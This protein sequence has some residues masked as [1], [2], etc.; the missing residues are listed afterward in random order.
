MVG[1][2]VLS[3]S[4]YVDSHGGHRT[5]ER[6]AVQL[7]CSFASSMKMNEFKEVQDM[8]LCFFKG[9]SCSRQSAGTLRTSPVKGVARKGR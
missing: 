8:S 2:C 9:K 1:N 6:V 4:V 7:V 3:L 5:A